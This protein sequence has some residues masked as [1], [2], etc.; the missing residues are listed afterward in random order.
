MAILPLIKSFKSIVAVADRNGFQAMVGNVAK[1][2]IIQD[3]VDTA[4][5]PWLWNENT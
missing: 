1:L 5:F 3:H 2:Y 4:T